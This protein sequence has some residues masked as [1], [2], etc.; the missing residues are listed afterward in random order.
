M[1]TNTEFTGVTNVFRKY[2]C[3]TTKHI[4]KQTTP[5]HIHADLCVYFTVCHAPLHGIQYIFSYWFF[6]HLLLL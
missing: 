1:E 4:Y 3:N 6:F 5:V 2:C